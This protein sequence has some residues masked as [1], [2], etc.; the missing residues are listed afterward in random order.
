[1]QPDKETIIT[2]PHSDAWGIMDQPQSDAWGI[3]DHIY[4]LIKYEKAVFYFHLPLFVIK[5]RRTFLIYSVFL[6]FVL[7]NVPFPH[8]MNTLIC[9]YTRTF[10]W[11][12]LYTARALP[13]RQR[14]QHQQQQESWL[15]TQS[16]HCTDIN[17]LLRQSSL[18][19]MDMG[20]GILTW[21]MSNSTWQ[22]IRC[23]SKQSTI[24][25]WGGLKRRVLTGWVTHF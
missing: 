12:K 23:S 16:E 11:L 15:A 2:E 13:I 7:S 22:N 24:P 14:Q 5:T 17:R 21:S 19:R 4:I 8:H 9:M 25:L 10:R 3:M 18:P 1:M 20:W 6:Y